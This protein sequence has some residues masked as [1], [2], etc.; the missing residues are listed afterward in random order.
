MAKVVLTAFSPGGL[1]PSREG[2]CKDVTTQAALPLPRFAGTS[3]STSIATQPS[4]HPRCS[5]VSPVFS[6]LGSR[7]AL[8]GDCEDYVL[9]EPGKDELFVNL[10]ELRA[11][12]RSWLENWPGR[13]LPT[14]LASFDNLDDAVTYLVE[15]ACEL[16]VTDGSGTVQWF[17]VRL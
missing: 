11:R 7:S 10:E 5:S 15:N 3:V 2:E 14:D 16:D 1:F 6:R 9:I 8:Y 17:G 12:L 4:V 13:S